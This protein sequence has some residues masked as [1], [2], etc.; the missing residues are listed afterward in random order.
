MTKSSHSSSVSLI[1]NRQNNNLIK[2]D[3]NNVV[4]IDKE[5]I[6]V[7]NKNILSENQTGREKLA[8]DVFSNTTSVKETILNENQTIN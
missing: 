2:S 7:I 8:I 1:M 5:T 3:E 4:I 6:T